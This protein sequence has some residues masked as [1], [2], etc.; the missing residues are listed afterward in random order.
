MRGLFYVRD[1]RLLHSRY[2]M[3]LD[4]AKDLKSMYSNETIGVQEVMNQKV[5]IFELI[6]WSA[7]YIESFQNWITN[8]N[9]SSFT[10]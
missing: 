3:C 4:L 9:F 8:R 1:C 10:I 7:A 5:G 6:P 2:V